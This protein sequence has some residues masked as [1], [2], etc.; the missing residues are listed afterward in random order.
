MAA[1][2][3][4]MKQYRYLM[5]EISLKKKKRGSIRHFSILSVEEEA[6]GWD[7]WVFFFFG[8]RRATFFAPRRARFVLRVVGR[9]RSPLVAVGRRLRKKK[10]FPPLPPS[11][12]AD[13]VTE[14]DRSD[15]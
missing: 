4:S 8:I 15:S 1:L 2:K 11:A 14:S 10:I 3:A 9:R 7:R 5:P 13:C 6:G 12:D